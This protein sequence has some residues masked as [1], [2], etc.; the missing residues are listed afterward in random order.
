MSSQKGLLYRSSQV[1]VVPYL[2]PD[3]ILGV[4]CSCSLLQGFL[5][6]C[7]I[8]L[9]KCLLDKVDLDLSALSRSCHRAKGCSNRIR[10]FLSVWAE[11]AVRTT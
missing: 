6:L 7:I 9:P 8:N 5:A 2:G 10:N 1:M 11:S 3:A 4:M